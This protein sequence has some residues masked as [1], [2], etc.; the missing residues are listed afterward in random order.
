ML[1]LVEF[2]KTNSAK[3]NSTTKKILTI[4]VCMS[5]FIYIFALG[6]VTLAKSLS[7]SVNI[8]QESSSAP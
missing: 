7:D 4:I 3:S 8:R 1:N 6:L 5:G 2:S